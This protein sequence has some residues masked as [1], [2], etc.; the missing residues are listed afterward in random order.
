MLSTARPNGATQALL[1]SQGFDASSITG[2][3]NRGLATITYERVSASAK[4]VDVRKVRITESG[5]EAL[6]AT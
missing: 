3:V 5:R 6:G 4:D 2:L 1:S